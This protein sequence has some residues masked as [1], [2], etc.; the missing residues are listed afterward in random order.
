[1][2]PKSECML[3]SGLAAWEHHGQTDGLD[4]APSDLQRCVYV[5]V[6]ICLSVHLPVHLPVH[7]SV[8]I[9]LSV[10]LRLPACLLVCPEREPLPTQPPSSP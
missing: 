1:M 5:C 3:V 8:Y 9:Y 10:C 2:D 6:Y 7:L 4:M